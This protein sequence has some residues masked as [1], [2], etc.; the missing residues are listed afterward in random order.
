VVTASSRPGIPQPGLQRSYWLREALALEDDP[1]PLPPPSEPAEHDVVIIGG[2]YTGLWT[3]YFLTETDPGIRVAIVE[4]DICG[5]GPSGRNG[6]FLHGWWDQL[7]ALV[8][9]FGP[10]RALELAHAADAAVEGTRTFC[11]RHSVDAWF[12]HSGYLRVSAS[13]GQDGDG[14]DAVDTCR[15]L[16]VPD[17]LVPLS[18]AEVQA[19][20]ASPAFRRGVFMRNAATVQPARLARGLRR[21]LLER[22]VVIHEGTRATDIAVDRD[23]RVRAEGVDL[24]APQ[25]V[26]AVN[27][28]AG[29]W[30][31]HRSSLV[32][33]GSYMVLTAPAPELL[34]RIGW[35]GG[36]AIADSRFTVHYFRTTPDGR[37]AFG[38]G[39]GAAGF[40]GRIGPSFERD[41]RAVER[42]TA[43]LRR[44]LPDLAE[45]EL[46]DAWGGPIDVSS[47]RLPIVGATHGGRVHHAY[48]YSGNGVGPAHLAGRILAARIAGRDDPVAA[49]PLGARRS[50]RFPPE[51]IRYVGARVVREALIRRDELEDQ[52]RR[53]GPIVR[54]LV[55]L[56]RVLGYR[57]GPQPSSART[58]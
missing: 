31:R 27:A 7:P 22:G 24:R 5:G 23:V 28:W 14:D 10:D 50:R 39:V 46:T 26:L 34:E 35:T 53:A 20:C 13:V 47:D 11:E 4:Q 56:P 1:T 12:R 54:L 38:A 51:P 33:W 9:L 49:L 45:V 17:E 52:G 6:G 16:G 8:E 55:R 40:G 57:L 29:G 21:V 42:A 25:A 32:A 48:G 15:G 30:P 41:G 37:V 58:E 19:R 3:A 43:G 2:G 18:P 44:L 36:E